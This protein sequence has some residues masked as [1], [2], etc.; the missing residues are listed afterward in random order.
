LNG[1]EAVVKQF[2][3]RDDVNIALTMMLQGVYVHALYL[4]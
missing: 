4:G 3:A 1:K 2:L